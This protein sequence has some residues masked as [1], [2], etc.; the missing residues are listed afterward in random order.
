MTQTLATDPAHLR[1]RWTELRTARPL[2]NR[3]A[4]A[5]LGVT[6]AQLVASLCGER[7]TRLAGDF[8]A[9]L[10]RL[11]ALRQV[12]TLTRNEAC[13]H[14]KT[15]RFEEVSRTGPVGLV[16]GTDIDLRVFL[17]RWQHGFLVDEPGPGPSLQFFD[18]SG[19]AVHKVY[20]RD[21]QSRGSW[22]ALVAE[23]MAPSQSPL[24][25]VEPPRPRPSE[26]ADSEIDVTGFR[27][28][29]AGL[30]DTHDFFGMLR[31]FGVT[32]TQ[33]L[34]LAEAQFAWPVPVDAATRLLEAAAADGQPIMVFVGNPGCIQIHT[35]PVA[36]VERRGDWINVLDPDFNLHLREDLVTAAWLVRKPTVD[37]IVTSVEL[38]DAR[39]ELIAQFFGARKPGLPERP[40]WRALAARL[41]PSIIPVL[42]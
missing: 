33:A 7:V 19:E 21:P 32:R 15:G 8:G 24:Q 27:A 18:A 16:L 26:K 3:E 9:L 11:P 2:R 38:F 25:P 22:D 29:W 34:R 39:H 23:F 4:A 1:H 31:R 40:E 41:F 17:D 10:Q 13:V 36:R 28:A 6:E 5:L 12:M 42:P 14:E 30:K 20:L 35:G 37:G